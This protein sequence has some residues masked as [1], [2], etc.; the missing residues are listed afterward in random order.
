MPQVF[1]Q[2]SSRL[3][4][5]VCLEELASDSVAGVVTA[6]LQQDHGHHSVACQTCCYLA[7]ELF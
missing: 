4:S 6:M 1:L 3:I 2:A 5:V 7:P